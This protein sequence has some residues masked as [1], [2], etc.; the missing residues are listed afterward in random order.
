V[1][2]WLNKYTSLVNQILKKKLKKDTKENLISMQLKEFQNLLEKFK[3]FS[4]K[5]SELH[6]MGFDFYEGKYQLVSYV[7][8]IIDIALSSHYTEHGVDWINWFI[9]ET[10]Y[11][12]KKLEAW[13]ENKN[14]ICQDLESLHE[15]ITKHHKK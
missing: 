10:D 13:D 11:G 2:K 3:S 15:Y 5:A 7:D 6:D 8:K 9:Y 4:D 1:F 14:L 12:N